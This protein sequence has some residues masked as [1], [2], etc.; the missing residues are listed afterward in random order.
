MKSVCIQL[1]IVRI[2]IETFQ[3][4]K[5]V[6]FYLKMPKYFICRVTDILNCTQFLQDFARQNYGCYFKVH[7]TRSFIRKFLWMI[8]YISNNDPQLSIRL[9][10]RYSVV[11]FYRIIFFNLCDWWSRTLWTVPCLHRNG[12]IISELNLFVIQRENTCWSCFF[13]TKSIRQNGR[14]F[15]KGPHLLCIDTRLQ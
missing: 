8:Q 11:I 6:V 7:L 13:L 14:I 15:D 10:L 3:L 5:R 1:L 12:R 9:S 2:F 4:L